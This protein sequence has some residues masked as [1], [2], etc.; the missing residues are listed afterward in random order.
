MCSFIF[1][2][3]CAAAGTLRNARFHT[4]TNNLITVFLMCICQMLFPFQ[5]EQ[6]YLFL[7]V[8]KLVSCTI[9]L[10]ERVRPCK[11]I[12]LVWLLQGLMGKICAYKSFSLK[13]KPSFLSC[14]FCSF[15]SSDI[16]CSWRR[17]CHDILRFLPESND[18]Q[19]S[20]Y[21]ERRLQDEDGFQR[22]FIDVCILLW[23]H[24]T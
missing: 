13:A 11:E 1:S 16:L 22:H 20:D 15:L 8:F 6:H 24:C 4:I 23:S 12:V 3:K 10:G 17:W 21:G 19:W 5:R 14:R 2:C 7:W 9:S 18:K